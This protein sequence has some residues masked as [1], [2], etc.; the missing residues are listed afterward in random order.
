MG[1]ISDGF[2]GVGERMR[3]RVEFSLANVVAW[4]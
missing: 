2:V 3:L 4:S 1:A